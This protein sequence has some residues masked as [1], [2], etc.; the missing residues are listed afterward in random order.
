MQYKTTFEKAVEHFDFLEVLQ[1]F[2][3]ERKELKIVFWDTELL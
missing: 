3:F 2:M 1:E